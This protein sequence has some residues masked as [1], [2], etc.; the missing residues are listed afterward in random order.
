MSGMSIP[1]IDISA[2]NWIIRRVGIGV[3]LIAMI[4]AVV[5]I[6]ASLHAARHGMPLGS[7][8]IWV[9]E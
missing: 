2:V 1:R 9:K 3:A 7:G 5:A 6:V 8:L 4:V